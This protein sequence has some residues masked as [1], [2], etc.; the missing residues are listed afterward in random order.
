MHFKFT[1]ALLAATLAMTAES[2]PVSPNPS[3][4]EV[5]GLVKRENLCGDS[6]FENQTSGA[7]P[8]VVDCQ[9]LNYNIRNGGTWFVGGSQRQLASYGDC[10]FGARVNAG[11]A[12]WARWVGNQDIIDLINDSIARYGGNGL[13]GAKGE[14]KCNGGCT[15][16]WGLY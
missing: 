7:S 5:I 4:S 8:R 10:A 16:D 9:Q 2:A 13:V 15:V 3:S 1:V 12:C 14:M 6:S 11:P